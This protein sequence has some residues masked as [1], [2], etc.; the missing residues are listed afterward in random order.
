M[1]KKTTGR[2]TKIV[3]LISLIILVGRLLYAAIVA[4]PYHQEKRSTSEQQRSEVRLD[5]QP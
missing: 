4:I 2:M 3:L 1:R 5:R